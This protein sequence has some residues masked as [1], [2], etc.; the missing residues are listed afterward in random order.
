MA[1]ITIP[2]SQLKVNVGQATPTGNLAMPF[3]LAS[4]I[5]Q[6]YG[7]IGKE[8][9]K[10]AKK[11]KDLNDEI[12]LNEIVKDAIVRIESVS[13]GVSKNS[14]LQFAVDLFDKKTKLDQFEDLYKKENTKVQQL[15]KLW[16]A[17]QRNSEY[18]KI[19][20][21]VTKNHVA[22]VKDFHKE[23]IQDIIL[24][25]ASSDIQTATEASEKKKSFFGNAANAQVYTES[26]WKQLEKETDQGIFEAR[27]EF[28]TKNH[29]KYILDN[30]D[31]IKDKVDPD[32]ANAIIKK[33]LQKISSDTAFNIKRDEFIR[34]AD[35]DNKIATFTELM[36][37]IKNDKTPETLGNIPTLD[38][39]ND[40]YKEDK[41]NSAQYG[42][43]I[44]FYKEPEKIA[45]NDGVFEVV[46]SQLYMAETV[47]D[48]DRLN[49]LV[50]LD[51]EYLKSIGIK[52]ISTI[53]AIIDKNKDR[54]A[55]E[56]FKYYGNLIDN[57]LGKIDA[58][59]IRDGRDVEKQEQMFRT[60]GA[61]M[62]NEYVAEGYRPE[63][64]FSKI[65]Q[66]YLLDRN[67]V[68]TIYDVSQVT[69]ITI[70]KPSK[71][72][73]DGQSSAEIFTGWRNQVLEKYKNNDINLSELQK[74]LASLDVMENVY[75]VR[76]EI[77]RVNSANPKFSGFGFF[78]NNTVLGQE[79][80]KPVVRN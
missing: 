32:K 25:S 5:G 2:Q 40:L 76:T 21:N 9:E 73:A 41:L 1:K 68:P 13:A 59:A 11:Q 42:A 7:A 45:D 16:H 77:E 15:F 28:G 66:T 35:E 43:L 57:V 78:E 20:G 34:K 58:V 29:P 24:D 17:K 10:V 3:S 74:D 38:F 18:V 33:A 62:Y 67:K 54:E 75:N 79:A 12:R 55:F 64:A 4:V 61:R 49:R 22:K 19:A 39:L 47:E 80:T 72:V 30:Y 23:T 51:T 69:S 52:D 26:E 50:H 6:G 60:V 71:Q 65:L 44:R 36:L 8:V 37:R 63:Q 70:T 53:S 46:N 56:N 48:L 31:E 27:V 14:D